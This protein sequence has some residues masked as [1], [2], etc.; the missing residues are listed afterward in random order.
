M[1]ILVG[2]SALSHN[3]LG[4]AV[5]DF[6]QVTVNLP[7]FDNVKAGHWTYFYRPF[8][9]SVNFLIERAVNGIVMKVPTK[10]RA[11]IDCMRDTSIVD[12]GQLCEAIVDYLEY[13][14]ND[15]SIEKLYEVADFFN[16]PREQVDWWI[17][18]AYDYCSEM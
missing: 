1:S 5:S 12:E 9:D 11:L 4:S 6:I 7:I 2:T 14:S 8:L 10:E 15:G 13:K 16:Y 18:E 17:S 3:G